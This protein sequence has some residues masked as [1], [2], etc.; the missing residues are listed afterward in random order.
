MAT[1]GSFDTVEREVG[2]GAPDAAVIWLHGLG[3]DANDFV[4]IVPMLGLE[5]GP[6]IRFVFPNAPVRPVTINGGMAMRAWFDIRKLGGRDLDEQRIRASAATLDVLVEREMPRH[7]RRP[8][9]GGLPA[10]ASRHRQR[11]AP[12]V[13]AVRT[14]QP[15]GLEKVVLG[16]LRGVAAHAQEEFAAGE[17]VQA[18]ARRLDAVDNLTAKSLMN[19][20]T[21]VTPRL[22]HPPGRS[23]ILAFNPR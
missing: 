19:V 2:A 20:H 7:P 22:S 12:R 4:P 10:I 3:A 1:S 15:Q 9:S 18:P 5:A 13:Q 14:E 6:G 17:R 21:H 8:P 11:L 23:A 16:V